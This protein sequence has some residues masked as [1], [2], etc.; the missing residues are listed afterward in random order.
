MVH[1]GH[2]IYGGKYR[3]IRSDVIQSKIYQISESNLNLKVDNSVSK[4]IYSGSSFHKTGVATKV[5][6][7]MCDTEAP[8]DD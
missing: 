7:E 3:S 8:Q 2:K 1:K 5:C 4:R 6:V